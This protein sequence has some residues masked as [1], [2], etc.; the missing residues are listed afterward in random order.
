MN[1]LILFLKGIIFGVANVIPGVSGGTIAVVLHIFDRLIEAI[2]HFT[3]DIKKHIMFLAPLGIGALAGILVFSMLIDYTLTNYSLPTCGFFAGLV[4][5]SIPLIYGMAKSKQPKNTSKAKY[6]ILAALAFAL[7]IFLSTLKTAEGGTAVVGDVPVALMF[8]AFIGGAIAAAAMICP[9]ISGSFM[10]VLLGLYNVVIG[11]VALVK[12]FL[13]TFDMTILISIIK[14]CAP[15]G[16]GIIFGAILIS[17]I[18]EFL[19][20]K[21]HTETYYIILGLILGSLIGIF[22]DP[23]AYGSYSGTIPF[24]AFIVSAVTAVCGFIVAVFL[25][26]E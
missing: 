2:N 6:F 13:V 18:I 10:L 4:A 23:I 8:K 14:F 17:R 11:Y 9:G 15:L 22:L 3:K 26:R 1:T 16:L 25:G 20:N 24:S 19:M 21:Y 7:V 12:D 5:G